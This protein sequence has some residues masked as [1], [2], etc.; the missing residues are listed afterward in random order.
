[1]TR[2][3]VIAYV[4]KMRHDAMLHFESARDSTTAH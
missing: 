3:Q 2:G 1:M 4:G